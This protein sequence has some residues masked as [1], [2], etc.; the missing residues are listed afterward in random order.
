LSRWFDDG[1][2]PMGLLTGAL[3][4]TIVAGA[5]LMLL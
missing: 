5:A 2:S 4:P 1:I 3:L